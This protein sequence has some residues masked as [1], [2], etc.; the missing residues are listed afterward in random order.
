MDTKT[1]NETIFLLFNNVD[2]M[3]DSEL[4]VLLSKRLLE[5]HRRT[6]QDAAIINDFSCL[7]S[8]TN[9]SSIMMQK[10][11][12]NK[13][14]AELQGIEECFANTESAW[15]IEQVVASFRA[16][17]RMNA[18]P[19]DQKPKPAPKPAFRLPQPLVLPLPSLLDK[20]APV[21]LTSRPQASLPMTS[22]C[23]FT[24]RTN[25]TSEKYANTYYQKLAHC[26]SLSQP[27][28]K[29]PEAIH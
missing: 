7:T 1:V 26:H 29:I 27:S 21:G 5:V 3:K 15:P 6:E 20:G 13:S 12:S 24:P 17:L 8:N 22:G 28:L 9:Q 2:K 18:K 25:P 19:V 23:T 11:A 10:A 4:A 16:K 14:M